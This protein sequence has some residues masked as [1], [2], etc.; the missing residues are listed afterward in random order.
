MGLVFRVTEHDF[1]RAFAEAGQSSQFSR[2]GLLALFNY[3]EGFSNEIGED[4]EVD[5]IGL[6]CAYAEYERPSNSEL[7]D[8]EGDDDMRDGDDY[9]DDVDTADHHGFD[10]DDIV[11]SKGSFVIVRSA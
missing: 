1:E 11:V 10:Q 2:E 7:E 3:L 6:C 9:A 4:Y 8:W 5:V